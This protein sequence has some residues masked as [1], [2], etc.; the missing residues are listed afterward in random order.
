MKDHK[1]R[2][3]LEVVTL[4]FCPAAPTKDERM[5]LRIYG[6]A[7]LLIAACTKPTV[8]P[9]EA[10][11]LSDTNGRS[12]AAAMPLLE[13]SPQGR[14]LL[15]YLVRCALPAEAELTTNAGTVAGQIGLASSWP[16]RPLQPV[17][18]RWV[19]ACLLA[20]MNATGEHVEISLAGSNPLL[21]D[22][23][24]EFDFREGAF[25]GNLFKADPQSFACSGDR[26]VQNSKA[27]NLRVCTDPGENGETQCGMQMAGQCE[28]AC[29]E[30]K[31]QGHAL[32]SCKGNGQDFAEVVTVFLPRNR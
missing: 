24:G 32:S 7:V 15:P 30:G 31:G 29:A 4:L 27:R 20:L 14:A 19:T 22:G 17:E 10:F 23:A 18:Q 2:D 16:E 6:A 13:A 9:D 28:E 25:Y 3:H 11:R 26:D 5:R 21:A 1:K 12:L 8:P